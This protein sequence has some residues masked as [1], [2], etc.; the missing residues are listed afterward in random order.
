MFRQ[1]SS[2]IL[3]TGAEIERIQ[4]V[5]DTIILKFIDFLE[6]EFWNFPIAHFIEQNSISKI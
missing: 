1:H 6:T 2:K 4:N 5:S 3:K